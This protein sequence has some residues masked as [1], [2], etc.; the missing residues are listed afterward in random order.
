MKQGCLVFVE[1]SGTGR[2]LGLAA[3]RLGLRSVLLAEDP[4]RYAADLDCYDEVATVPTWDRHAIA[5]WCRGY[6]DRVVGI[7]SSSEYFIL[8]AAEVAG[9]LGLSRP[10]PDAVARCRN[11]ADSRAYLSAS[12]VPIPDWALCRTLT[13]VANAADRLGW[14]VVV[15]PVDG[16]GSVGVRLA[17]D[18]EQ[19]R[20]AA[21]A[22]LLGGAN[23]ISLERV[24]GVLVESYVAGPELSV[25]VWNGR[26]V[27]VVRKHLGPEPFFVETGHDVPAPLSS[28]DTAWLCHAA[29]RAVAALG[30]TWGPAHVELR[31]ADV[32]KI[33]EVNPRLAD[34]NIPRLVQLA[35]GLDLAE[36]HVAQLAGRPTPFPEP[37]V[38]RPGGHG[39]RPGQRRPAGG[40]GGLLAAARPRV[41]PGRRPH[42]P[43]RACD[44]GGRRPRRGRRG[45]RGRAEPAGRR[46]C[47]RTGP[48]GLGGLNGCRVSRSGTSPAPRGRRQVTRRNAKYR[49][50][51]PGCG[52]TCNRP[53]RQI[54]VT[55][56]SCKSVAV[57]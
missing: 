39:A 3:R 38:A 29:E 44:R 57:D 50:S 7:G 42:R 49:V 41:P 47:V 52:C 22:L 33:I 48:A 21:A 11:K 23:E 2:L 37:T 17:A 51:S 36:C 55:V 18:P 9:Y 25:E 19:A 27:T 16:S 24:P 6:P 53:F 35:T 54:R 45:R 32:P 43:G 15:K 20:E 34:G 1:S 5:H 40:G 46:V 10:A 56:S 14:P 26:A 8:T 13:D 31:M 30:L 4:A 12:G 28:V